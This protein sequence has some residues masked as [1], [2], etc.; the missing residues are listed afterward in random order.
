MK[1]FHKLLGQEGER[2]AEAFLR[3]K[4]YVFVARNFR[5]KHAEIDLIFTHADRLIFAEVKTMT[6]KSEALFGSPSQTIDRNKRRRNSLAAAEFLARHKETFANLTPQF[7]V[8]EVTFFS[9]KVE[10][11]HIENAFPA[12][13]GFQKKK[14]F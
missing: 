5:A 13:F 2:H 10:I 7:D 6:E 1:R 8:L 9:K 14:L 11:S 12:E 4:G 3:K